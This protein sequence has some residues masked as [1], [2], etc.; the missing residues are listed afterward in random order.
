MELPYTLPSALQNS[1]AQLHSTNSNPRLTPKK[2]EASPPSA[3]PQAYPDT[4]KSPTDQPQSSS[5]QPPP[6]ARRPSP[7]NRDNLPHRPPHQPS[8]HPTANR[9]PPVSSP[10]TAQ[11]T[12]LKHAP[13]AS[14]LHRPAATPGENAH[15]VSPP[16]AHSA[17]NSRAA[18]AS[19]EAGRAGLLQRADRQPV[20]VVLDEWCPGRARRSR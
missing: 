13:H 12:G 4:N 18:A 7:R 16:A 15:A 14:T 2:K 20:R 11:N 17:T 6:P 10:A 5:P 9:T 3:R 1:P 19:R 8:T